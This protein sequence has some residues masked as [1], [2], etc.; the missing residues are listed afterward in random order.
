MNKQGRLASK[1]DGQG[2]RR[3]QAGATKDRQSFGLRQVHDNSCSK[4]KTTKELQPVRLSCL[5]SPAQPLRVQ[6]TH[7]R[8]RHKNLASGPLRDSE[9]AGCECRN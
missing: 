5:Q 8:I 6:G 9:V 2:L 4:G 3:D 1:A 7:L